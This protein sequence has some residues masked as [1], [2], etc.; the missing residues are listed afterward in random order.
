MKANQL[1]LQ[2]LIDINPRTGIIKLHDK[3]MGL[4]SV[5]ALSILRND[6]IETLGKERTKGFL[7]RYGWACGKRAAESIKMRYD[8][9]SLEELILSGTV[10]HTLEGIVT[11]EPDILEIND[12]HLYITGYWKN[13]FESENH[14]SENEIGNEPICWTLI[15]YA[16]GYLT[17]AFGKEVIAYEKKCRGKGDA[18]CYFVAETVAHC[19][20][21]H[22]L[23]LRYYQSESMQSV[24]DDMY[25]EIEQLNENI[26]ESE[27]IQNQLTE[28]FLED[29]DINEIIH[30]LGTT[31]G[32]SI[33]IDHYNEVYSSYFEWEEER[34]A[35]KKLK[36][37]GVIT[38]QQNGLFFE[39]F[40]IK[41]NKVLLGNLMVIG[42]QKLNQREQL[43]IKRALVVFTIQM[44][45]QR[46]LTESLW[47]KREDFF[48]ELIDNKIMDE[49]II[50]R[51]AAIFGFNINEPHRIIVL[52][53]IPKKMK[54]RVL[55][56][57]TKRF[58]L[59]DLFLKD[60]FIVIISAESEDQDIEVLSVKLLNEIKASLPDIIL[61]IGSG[62]LVE[63]VYKLKES[64]VDAKQICDFVQLTYP[65]SSRQATYKD[66]EGIMMFLKGAD[67]EELMMFYMKTIG[68]L[69]KY[70]EAN[71]GSL[72]I[73]LKSFLDNNGNLQQ[74]ADD[75]HLS[76][77]GLRY[78]IEKIQSLSDID[79]K[80][81]SGR[82]NGQL[83]TRIY[84]GLKVMRN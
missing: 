41:S 38:N 81:G 80:T 42:K 27:K 5:E 8:W 50:N 3:R 16:S 44:Y 75:L 54:E 65:T 64:Y 26:I 71:S 24:L 18:E 53:V 84:F 83:A 66:F 37:S 49:N 7:M 63:S 67:H 69:V 60:H 45:H 25:A 52:K 72:L 4:I 21:T 14:L 13:S 59:F 10:M 77:A 32:R 19:D 74:T 12:D 73:T 58:P 35:Y 22:L 57:L 17:S 48:D 39:S 34:L 78:R 79:L 30:T 29:K 47:N 76:I 46:K 23:D 1:I 70:D 68:T 62:R 43:I 36:A 11:V 20:E 51:Q 61:H 9:E 28:L 6:L 2:N 31:L 15:G 55:H 82:F 33:V 56:F 40:L